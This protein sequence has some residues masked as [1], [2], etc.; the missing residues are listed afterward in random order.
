M[1]SMLNF[2]MRYVPI[3]TSSGPLSEPGAAGKYFG[4]GIGFLH[5]ADDVDI[6]IGELDLDRIYTKMMCQLN[7]LC[8]H[9]IPV[10]LSVKTFFV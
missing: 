3:D 4:M 8:T 5:L 10:F 1:R 6:L 9:E 2:T 7:V